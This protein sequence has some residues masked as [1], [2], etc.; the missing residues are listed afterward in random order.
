ML[1]WVS[2]IEAGEVFFP[3]GTAKFTPL[4]KVKFNSRW[5]LLS[6]TE[7]NFIAADKVLCS[8]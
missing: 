1:S 7:V 8:Y 4:H 6:Q 5:S 3:P 2:W